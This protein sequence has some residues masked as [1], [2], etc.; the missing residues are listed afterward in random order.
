VEFVTQ[1]RAR[2]RV[3]RTLVQILV[4]VANIQVTSLKTEVEKGSMRTA[5]GHGLVGPKRWGNSVSS[6]DFWVGRPSKGD[7]VKIP[8]PGCGEFRRQRK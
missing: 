5:N 7:W 8:E 3:K 1:P 4:V 2:A 6:A